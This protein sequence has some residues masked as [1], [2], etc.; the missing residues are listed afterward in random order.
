MLSGKEIVGKVFEISLAGIIGGFITIAIFGTSTLEYKDGY[1]DK[2]FDIPAKAPDELIIQHKGKKI[3]NISVYDFAIYNRTFKDLKDIT[4]F[5]EISPK[6]G[7]PNQ[8][9]ISRG[10]YPP[11]SLPEEIGITEVPQKNKNLYSFKLDV[12][13][14]TGSDTYYLAR[15]IFEGKENPEIRV[16]IP[17]NADVDIDK[18][19][20]LREYAIIIFSLVGMVLAIIV[21]S[22]FIDG[23]QNKGIWPKRVDRLIE[24]LNKTQ[25]TTLT[26]K[27]IC[28]ILK[29]YERE[30]KPNSPFFYRKASEFFENLK[31]NKKVDKDAE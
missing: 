20:N 28:E 15:F 5:F 9:I 27:T 16:S 29:N 26:E 21:F 30:F 7:K 31:S 10:L 19:S 2:Y 8:E 3:E 18:Y 11:S 1:K 12:V 23:W 17:K 4:V 24:V 6:D 22:S 14:Q 25:E 13:K